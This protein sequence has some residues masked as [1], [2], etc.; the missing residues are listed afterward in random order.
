[1]TQIDVP[2][3][4]RRARV[5]RRSVLVADRI[6]NWTIT[7]GGLLVSLAVA[8]IM[9]LLLQVVVPLFNGARVESTREYSIERPEGRIALA[10]ADEY[11]SRAMALTAGGAIVNWHMETGAPLAGS[12]FDLGGVEVT[13]F[14]RSIDRTNVAFGL[15]DGPVRFGSATFV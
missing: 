12:R 1:M 8:G 3:P 6:A 15:A 5:T 9:L 7:V 11:R 10:N 13:S 2:M 14:A 4:A